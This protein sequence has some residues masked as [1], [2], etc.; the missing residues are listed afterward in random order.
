MIQLPFDI[1]D[2]QGRSCFVVFEDA[3]G[4]MDGFSRTRRTD[5][6][7]RKSLFHPQ[8]LAGKITQ[9]SALF[10]EQ[11]HFPSD[12][13]E[14]GKAAASS[15]CVSEGVVAALPKEKGAKQRGKKR[16]HDIE[17]NEER[18]FRPFSDDRKP[19]SDSFFIIVPFSILLIE[20]RC[21][22]TTKKLL[23]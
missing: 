18:A 11:P 9:D 15:F 12:C 6:Q 2:D 5:K 14:F 21:H 10:D 8:A 4:G 22:D 17:E 7:D 1:V 3:G 20:H 19:L 23:N 13:A 16:Q